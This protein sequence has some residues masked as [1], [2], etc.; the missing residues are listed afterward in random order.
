MANSSI[1]ESSFLKEAFISYTSYTN[2]TKQSIQKFA[3]QWLQ[4]NIESELEDQTIMTI[5]TQK[6]RTGTETSVT[7]DNSPLYLENL[8]GSYKKSKTNQEDALLFIHEKVPPKMQE[9]FKKRWSLKTKLEVSNPSGTEF[10]TEDGEGIISYRVE[11]K[12][13]YYLLSFE[14]K[15]EQYTIVLAEKISPQKYDTWLVNKADV[16]ISDV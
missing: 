6:W 11:K 7:G 9:E 10:T 1:P 12:Q 8:P 4:S 16:K 3:L 13:I 15:G 5:F 2:T 14:E